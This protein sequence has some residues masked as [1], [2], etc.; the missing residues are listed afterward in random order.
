MQT[1]RPEVSAALAAIVDTAT[2]KRVEDRYADDAELIADLEDVLAI[3]TARAGS[4]T[5]EVTSV[6]R[7]LPVPDPA[8]D[9]VP[10]P[11]PGPCRHSSCCCCSRSSAAGSRGSRPGPTTAPRSSPP[12]RPAA[13]WP[14]SACADTARTTTTPTRSAGRRRRTPRSTAWPSTA[15][16]TPPG[17]PSTT[18]R[19]S[20]ARPASGCTSTRAAPSKPTKI[21]VYTQTP[22]W[23]RPDLGAATPRP[24][25]RCSRPAPGGWTQLAAARRRCSGRSRSRSTTPKTGYRYYLVWITALPP[26]KMIVVL[27][28]IALYKQSS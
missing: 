3:E 5:G 4:A 25:P 2:A 6:L 21:V 27:N 28:E 16:S 19:A 1:K 7:T 9:P 11:P 13:T 26:G 8:P 14:R 10:S 22:G 12:P 24:I 20:S 15:T 18:T 23:T 17:R